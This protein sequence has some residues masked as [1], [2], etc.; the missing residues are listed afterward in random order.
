MKKLIL[1]KVI[2]NFIL[3]HSMKPWS[4]IMVQ[5]LNDLVSEFLFHNEVTETLKIVKGPEA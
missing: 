4:K 1:K 3:N 2:C 5:I